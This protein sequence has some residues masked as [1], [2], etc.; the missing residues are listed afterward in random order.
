MLMFI[1]AHNRAKWAASK[2]CLDP[3]SHQFGGMNG[4]SHGMIYVKGRAEN[5]PFQSRSF[6]IVSSIDSLDHFDNVDLALKEI[7]R[8]LRVGGVFLL[9]VDLNPGELAPCSL[10]S[11]DFSLVEKIERYGFRIDWSKETEHDNDFCP[12]RGVIASWN[13]P[14]FD[15]SG[16][17]IRR[18][19][20][21]L[22][23]TK[24][25]TH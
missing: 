10:H 21:T 2:I 6:D 24:L 5:M 17:M 16:V 19:F 13:C 7:H 25:S 8:V 22:R 14:K 23:A 15:H 4:A 1:I 3:L 12:A 18:A 20:L 9:Y 11:F